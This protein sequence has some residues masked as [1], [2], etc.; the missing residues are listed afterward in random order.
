VV[1]VLLILV[2]LIPLGLMLGI[3][4][5]TGGATPLDT[6]VCRGCKYP[7]AGLLS[8]VCPE[9]G[10]PLLPAG[11]L[12]PGWEWAP[13]MELRYV[14]LF[15]LTAIVAVPCW[16]IA[17]TRENL[18]TRDV[19]TFEVA[20][21]TREWTAQFRS[22]GEQPYARSTVSV[23]RPLT[24]V[25]LTVAG[26]ERLKLE[27]I[28][29]GRRA[30]YV[31]ATGERVTTANSVAAEDVEAWAAG[32]R[33]PAVRQSIIDLTPSLLHCLELGPSGTPSVASA[34]ELIVID[35]SHSRY[36][37]PPLRSIAICIGI[38]LGFFG[39]GVYGIKKHPERRIRMSRPKPNRGVEP[40]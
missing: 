24:L 7:T 12:A 26:G 18:V 4:G 37:Y 35:K 38:V 3:M 8:A 14:C 15:L 13:P 25:T 20:P 32:I 10:A 31:D 29:V 36:D 28:D 17:S 27:L 39:A 23:R 33:D 34:K 21:K 2:L 19:L 30:K 16:T 5:I 22:V 11:S 40:L 6:T 9:C 1:F